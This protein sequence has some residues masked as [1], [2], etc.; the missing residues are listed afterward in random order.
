M[1][2]KHKIEQWFK[3]HPE[4]KDGMIRAGYA[5]G[6]HSNHRWPRFPPV[7]GFD[8][9]RHDQCMA[10]GRTRW[11]I[12]HGAGSPKCSAWKP[13]DIEGTIFNEEETFFNLIKNSGPTIEKV[14][15]KRGLSGETLSFL[16]HTHGIDIE[17][18]EAHVELNDKLRKDYMI[19][20]EKH[21]TTGGSF[22]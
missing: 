4:D 21:C 22:K 5:Y 19:E 16:H 6:E 13:I 17:V 3:E 12:R 15:R 9:L 10:C 11:E 8:G 20:W 18:V 1:N 14:I 7:D 2:T